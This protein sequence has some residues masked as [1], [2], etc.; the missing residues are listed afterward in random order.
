MKKNSLF[1]GIMITFLIYVVL[2]WIIPS[3]TFQNGIFTKGD[4]T[5]VG[6]G[7]IFIYPI[8][9]SIT[10]IF[11]LTGLII[12]LIGSLYSVMNKTGA[13]QNLVENI[14]KKFEGKKTF[15]IISIL[16]FAILSSLTTLTLPL[17]VLVPLF[18]AVILK[19]GYNKMTAMLSTIGAILVGNMGAIFGYNTGGRN[20]INYF[21][22]LDTTK[23][24]WFKISLF[25]LLTI[26]LLVFVIKTSKIE[27][28]T[29][30]K[31]GKT[32]EKKA[33]TKDTKEAKKTIKEEEVIIPLY[34]S[35]QKT[36]NSSLKLV[37]IMIL[38]M[39]ISLVAMFNWSGALNI[40]TTIFD[41]W[42]TNITK[43]ELNGYPLFE[44]LIGSINPF[45]YWSNYEFAMLLVITILL[46]GAM[47]KLKFNEIL[48]SA[49]EGMKK[50][51]PVAAV[52]ILA[53]ILLLAVNSVASTFFATIFNGL[54][55]MTKGLNVATMSA[56]S[57]IGSV[58]YSDFLYLMNILYDP[59]TS[60]YPE[61]YNIAV[62]IMQTIYGLVMLLVPTSV[63]LVIGLQYLNISYKEWLK[64][65][66]KL[67]LCLLLAAL[68]IIITMILV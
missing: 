42:Y 53:N 7:N 15:L 10:S 30:K 43:I 55:E 45:G 19:L 21:F 64:E 68:I 50:M 22:G 36:K 67:L 6:I 38:F 8:S 28:L 20:Y 48:D 39:I 4:T 31:A 54:F 27:K 16:L 37:I 2:S 41:T 57:A 3:G 49:F 14:V 40:N 23:D 56:I 63:G 18:V 26:I 62:F 9:T 24:I 44:N 66:W 13:Y 52:A 32:T 61:N 58:A 29:K 12:L 59:V 33:S 1:K 35:K 25:V 5:P 46:I 51:L 17:L 65:N 34:D 47:Y 11:V 60:L